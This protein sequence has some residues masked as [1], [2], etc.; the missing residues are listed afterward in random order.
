MNSKNIEKDNLLSLNRFYENIAF[1]KEDFSYYTCPI[2][3]T[4]KKKVLDMLSP[5][6]NDIICDLGCGDG[7][8]SKA[9]VKKV[10]EVHGLDISPTRVKR[11]KKNGIKAICSDACFTP[12]ESGFFDKVICTEVIE[13]VVDPEKL[14]CEINRILKNNGIAVLTV[15]LM[16]KIEKTLLDVPK[17]DLE[18]MDYGKMIR[19]Y[20]ITGAHLH[21]FSEQGIIKLLEETGYRIELVKYTHEYEPKFKKKLIYSTLSFLKKK[22]NLIKHSR[23]M[24]SIF[25]KLIFSFYRKK[26][27]ELHHIIILACKR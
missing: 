23:V 1:K 21:S 5:Q 18:Q 19:K 17:I 6:K 7:N 2:G 8:L 10:K 14:I 25:D 20:N 24:D 11:A 12:F 22:V 9:I 13:H 16:Q 4:R 27:N 26:E 3:I 15:P